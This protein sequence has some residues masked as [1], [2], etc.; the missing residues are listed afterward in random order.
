MI[1]YLKSLK[2]TDFTADNEMILKSELVDKLNQNLTKGLLID[3]KFNELLV[4]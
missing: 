1:F 3:V 4:Q 2:S